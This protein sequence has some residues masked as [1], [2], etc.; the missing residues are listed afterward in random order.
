VGGVWSACC[1]REGDSP[2]DPR[3]GT[4]GAERSVLDDMT[5]S[6]K[7]RPRMYCVISSLCSEQNSLSL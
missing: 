3:S 7:G 6:Q 2:P 4:G 5:S 1:D